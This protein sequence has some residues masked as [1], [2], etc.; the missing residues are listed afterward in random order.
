MNPQTLRVIAKAT[1]SLHNLALLLKTTCTWNWTRR[2]AG[3]Q[4]KASPLMTSTHNTEG[5]LHATGGEGESLMS[6]SYKIYNLWKQL[7][8]WQWPKYSG[9]KQPLLK[10]VFTTHSTWW[11]PYLT[12]LKWPRTSGWIGH[13]PRIKPTIIIL[14]RE[15]SNKTTPRDI[16]LYP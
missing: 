7:V 8:V 16:V 10:I 15:K 5:T 9:N 4:L 2:Q 1:G 13:G 3:A 14:L 6:P 12:Q 11:N